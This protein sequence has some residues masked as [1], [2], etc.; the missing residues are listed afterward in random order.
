MLEKAMPN[1]TP[2]KICHLCQKDVSGTK[3]VKDPAGH[4][5]CQPCFD[6]AAAHAP[7]AKAAQA[8]GRP[9]GA[10]VATTHPPAAKPVAVK[11]APPPTPP[12][13]QLD[14]EPLPASDE[15]D[16]AEPPPP[17]PK[18]KPIAPP[19]AARPAPKPGVLPEFCPACGTKVIH[20]RRLC[21]KCQ[22]DVTKPVVSKGAAVDDRTEAVATFVGKALKA[23]I[24]AAVLAFVVFC[25]YGLYIMFFS[26]R[27]PFDM[28]PKTRE[29]AVREFLGHVARGGDAEY[30]KALKLISFRV[31]FGTHNEN[32][33][34]FYKVAFA[35]MHDELA[36]K[37]GSDWLSKVKI[38]KEG[39]GSGEDEVLTAVIDDARY[40]MNVQVQ[41]P[42]EKALTDR[43]ARKVES[44]PEDGKRHF[45]I[46]EVFD[47]PPH[48]IDKE[49]LERER[50]RFTLPG[51]MPG[52]AG[53][54][55][56]GGNNED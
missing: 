2:Q 5:F 39:V 16:F 20:G 44:Y 3:R 32:E 25:G 40:A 41:I 53:A 15:L 47:Y 21:I 35:R 50:A 54:Q 30:D 28:Y 9:A 42:A 11:I 4:Y 33:D 23:G 43:L 29:A 22:R 1:T 36:Q 48:P 45:G 49:Q 34:T 52:G 12:T 7:A 31:R 26:S 14:L 10:K 13:P 18:P 37:H 27:D 38:D 8:G 51:M 17:T 19:A 46:A 55:P 24:L 6:K 56:A